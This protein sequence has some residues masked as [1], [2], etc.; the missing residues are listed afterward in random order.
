[1]EA[2]K[3]GSDLRFTLS[4]FYRYITDASRASQMSET[5]TLNQI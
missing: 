2:V 4:S 1:M 3:I 5:N